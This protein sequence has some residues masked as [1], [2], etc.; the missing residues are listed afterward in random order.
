MWL[1]DKIKALGKTIYYIVSLQWGKL[2]N[3]DWGGSLSDYYQQIQEMSIEDIASQ[4]GGDYT[5][6]AIEQTTGVGATYE[7]GRAINITFDKESVVINTDVI[8]G[9]NGIQELSLIIWDNIQEAIE[10]NLAGGL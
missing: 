5:T 9:D 10:L 1:I 4:Y 6:T 3:V 2:G 8:A 7:A